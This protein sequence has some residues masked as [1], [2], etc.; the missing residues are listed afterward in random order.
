[1]DACSPW[2][3]VYATSGNHDCTSYGQLD[4]NLWKQYSGI[5]LVYEH[6]VKLPGGGSDHFLFLGMSYWEFTAPYLESHI[7]WLEDK[8][9]KYRNER[10]FVITHLF[11]PDRA[12]NMNDIYPTSNWLAGAQLDRLQSLC[13]NYVNSIWISGHSHWKWSMQKYQDRANVHRSYGIDGH[14]SSGW[15]IHVP[16]CSYPTDSD[17]ISTR[18]GRPAESEGAIVHVYEDHFDIMGIDLKQSLYLPIGTYR[19]DTK[20]E[21]VPEKEDNTTQLYL[22]AEN[23]AYYK[24]GHDKFT[25]RDVEDMPG[26]VEVTFTGTSQGYYVTNSTY[27]PSSSSKV[28]IIVEDVQAYHGGKPISVPEKV[29]F[30]G[31]DYFMTTTNSAYV[32]KESGVQFQTSSSC[33][34]PWPLTLRMKVLMQFY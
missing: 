22:K 31:G 28:S 33:G 20:L 26:Y 13:D 16:S 34:G 19:I 30:Y 9:E 6:A 12:G 1:M 25:V 24:G 10:C 8:L 23:F 21:E 29:G 14:P 27:V 3:P 17:G 11:F 32:N 15:C 7:L 2:T 4:E 18:E 5:P